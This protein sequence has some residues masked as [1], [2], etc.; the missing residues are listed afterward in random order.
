M[1]LYKLTQNYQNVLE[2]AEQLDAETLKDTLDSIDEAINDKVE[3][4]A[5]VIKQ[6]GANV[7]AYASEIKR[8]QAAKSA[9]E[10][11]AK[12]LKLYIQESMEKVGLDKVQGKLIKVAIQKN[13]PSVVVTDEKKLSKYFI[14]QPPQLNKTILKEDLNNGVKVDGAELQSTR[15][16]RIR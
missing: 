3:N 9:M 15:S 6:L 2:I 11:N 8:M 14:E 4:T 1:N 5:Y 10:N 16:I 7:D 12:N 13:Q